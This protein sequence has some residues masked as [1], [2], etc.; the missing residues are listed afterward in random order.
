MHENI[1]WVAKL[2]YS[3]YLFKWILRWSLSVLKNCRD[4]K[5]CRYHDL[6]WVFWIKAECITKD[7][8]SKIRE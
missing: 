5:Q 8:I 6:Y 3:I 4:R 2:K 7:S 1:K